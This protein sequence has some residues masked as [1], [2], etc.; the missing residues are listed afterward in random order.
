MSKVETGGIVEIDESMAEVRPSEVVGDWM[1]D[2]G[3]K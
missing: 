2:D 3:W 1:C